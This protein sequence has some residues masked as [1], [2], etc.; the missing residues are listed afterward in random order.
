MFD[1]DKEMVNLSLD[2]AFA[3]I[4]YRPLEFLHSLPAEPEPEPSVRRVV[5][6]NLTLFPSFGPDPLTFYRTVF[7]RLR[8]AA[9]SLEAV[10]LN[11]G[12]MHA[13][14]DGVRG[15]GGQQQP[16]GTEQWLAEF[17]LIQAS[18]EALLQA[19]EQFQVRVEHLF[20]DLRLGFPHSV[21]SASAAS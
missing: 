19:A 3:R 14:A 1:T 8:Q 18:Y 9:P 17:A 12:F 13:C 15:G 11:G 7:G 21:S 10:T 2:P 6:L 20:L 5:G 4:R 16:Q